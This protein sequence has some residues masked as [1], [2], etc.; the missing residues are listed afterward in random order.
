[1]LEA[2]VE[3]LVVADEGG[4]LVG[5]VDQSSLLE[6]DAPSPL[7][8]RQRVLRATHPEEVASALE[9][10]PRLALRL[11]DASV[12]AVDVLDVLTTATDAATRR[13]T[14]LAVA[15]LGKPPVPWAWLTLGSAAR[16]EQTLATDQDNGIAFEGSGTEVDA[17]FEA[18]AR[19]MND[20]LARCGYARCRAA[21]MAEN[22]GW[23]LSRQ[24]WIELF[25][26]WLRMPTSRNV[27]LAMIGFDVRSEIGP[28]DMERD[29][30][31]VLETASRRQDFLDALA[32]SAVANRPPLGFLRGLV[33]D[34]SGQHVGTLDVKTG[35]I[36]PIV[37]LARL[38]A[39]S[40]GS[41]TKRTVQRLRAAA[42]HGR[43]STETAQE[44]EEAF[45]TL[46]R[47][48]LEH[49]AAQV[50]RGAS[51]DNH[52]DPREVPPLERRQLKEAFRAIARAQHAVDAR[53]ATRIP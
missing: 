52:V 50:E 11:L 27:Q 23:R 35:G 10:L 31:D 21:V 5:V 24:G 20:S 36:L 28:L 15:D 30:E 2:D 13:L 45:A 4:R 49:Q 3:G 47:I 40:V 1:M 53:T 33:V 48:R 43:V 39:L 16:R 44:L 17:Y 18:F 32:R 41:T 38:Y 7:L 19:L 51:P 14:E 12:E 9:D 34:R 26:S 37:N 29:L 25:E 8:L 46:S 42:A 6:I 22:P